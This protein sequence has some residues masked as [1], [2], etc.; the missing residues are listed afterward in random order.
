MKFG[1][2]VQFVLQINTHRFG[3]VDVF[4]STA[5]F[6]DGGDDA[7]SH[8]NVLPLGECTSRV[9]PTHMRQRPPVST[10]FIAVTYL[11]VLLSYR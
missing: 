8:G 4:D 10:P 7:I 9:C 2:I 1:R 11:C 6:K 3:G 5:H